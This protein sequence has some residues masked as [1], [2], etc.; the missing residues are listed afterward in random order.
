MTHNF[1]RSTWQ[2][3]LVLTGISSLLYA[4]TNTTVGHPLD[5][6]KT[7]MQAKKE[8]VEGHIGFLKSVQKVWN[9]GGIRGFYRGFWPPFFGSIIFRTVQFA[10]FEAVMTRLKDHEELCKKVPY[11]GG[12]EY[13]LFVGSLTSSTI[14]CILETPFEYAKVKR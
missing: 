8:N 11:T 3:E 9:E 13:R 10:S 7:Q 1:E 2:R 14:R 5:L 4:A 6:I 12:I